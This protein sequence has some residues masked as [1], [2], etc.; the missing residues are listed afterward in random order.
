MSSIDYE[1]DR[2]IKPLRSKKA[3][4]P[5]VVFQ[6]HAYQGMQQGIN[7]IANVVRP[8]LGPLPRIVAIDPVTRGNVKPEL[9]DDGGVIARR[10]VALADQDQDTGA[11]FLR[12]VLWRQHEQVGDG[13]ATTAVLFQS[14]YNQGVKY[15]V[16]GG[17]PMQMR[18][19]FETGLR[20]ILDELE[21][22]AVPLEGREKIAQFAETLCHD[23]PL[24]K[25]LGEIFDIIGEYGQ[26]E[27]REGR[28]RDLEREYIEGAYFEGGLLSRLM[29]TDPLKR[30]ADLEEATVL[31][32]NL[33]IQEPDQLAPILRAVIEANV[34]SLVVVANEVSEKA[35]SAL[36]VA[37]RD[38]AQF[39][40][41]AVKAPTDIGGQAALIQ[42]LALLTGGRA[43]L[44]AAGD[45]LDG[46][47][48]ED[49]GRA[50]KAWATTEHFGI[51]AGKGSPRALR[52]HI[53]TLRQTVEKAQDSQARQKIRER[54][55]KLI[56]GSAVLWVGGISEPEIKARTQLAERTDET[57]RS[58]ITKGVLPGGGVSL[59]AC[60]PALQKMADRAKC[61]DERT[62]YRIL[63]RALEEP[64]RTILL[65]AGYR[66]SEY[67]GKINQAGPGF[68]FDVRCGKIVDMAAAGVIDSAGVLSHAVHAAISSAALAL[69][70]D[71]LVHKK[72]PE[73]SLEP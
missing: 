27:I 65:N 72:R 15:V 20:I 73:M 42:D 16:A 28:S 25:M 24:A 58:A 23:A 36:L 14:I 47:R 37:S 39:L 33:S 44:S 10:V 2:F 9:L 38:P 55:G 7:M 53:A 31:A 35:L 63:I 68:G 21:N 5:D 60:C 52:A 57:L 45:T 56:G 41:I 64:T 22:M 46:V 43:V 26:L 49:L 11:M 12:Q 32:S 18:S 67:I 50:R 62:A 51:V 8:T 69:T 40:A 30:R 66:P 19:Y 3:Q 34:K 61:L 48:L 6:P 13:T 1:F 71:V 29:F 59:L 4:T 70:V 54:I 17:N